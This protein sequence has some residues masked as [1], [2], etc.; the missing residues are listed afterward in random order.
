[1]EDLAFFTTEDRSE[2]S[3]ELYS[4]VGRALTVATHYDMNCKALA[5]TLSIREN[6]NLLDDQDAFNHLL[7]QLCKRQ[8]RTSIDTFTSR[9][10]KALKRG[11]A[12]PE[13]IEAFGATIF[14]FLKEGCE[15]RNYIAH[16]LA[17]GI[18]RNIN[19]DSFR[20]GFL[21]TTREHI[22]K[23]VKADFYIS[24]F[25]ENHI[26][27]TQVHPSLES[28]IKKICDWVCDVEV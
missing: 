20:K 1:M 5:N 6:A 9:I 2:Y 11:G 24:V 3:D 26:N 23:I 21:E 19:Q 28:Y 22:K 16:D 17:A 13:I 14:Q 18:S 8:L 25:M 10:R 12:S 7:E 15:S 27:N 4:V